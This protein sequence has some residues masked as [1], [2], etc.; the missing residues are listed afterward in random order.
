MTTLTSRLRGVAALVGIIAIVAGLPLL[1]VAAG[2]YPLADIQTLASS[3]GA[4]LLAP[5]DG[6]LALIVL[7]LVAWIA[8]VLMTLSLLLEAA[9]LVRGAR[10]PRLPGF[11]MPQ[12]VARALIG[13]A[14]LAFIAAPTANAAT[15][16]AAP[17]P[18]VHEPPVTVVSAPV[19][20]SQAAT[21]TTAEVKEQDA[22]P[23]L[24]HT[25]QAGDTLWDIAKTYLGDGM[26]FKEIV[27][28]NRNVLGDNPGFLD[29]GVE[30]SIPDEQRAGREAPA[31]EASAKDVVVQ[32][33]DTL[34][35]IAADELGDPGLYPE[36][37][38]A[39]RDITQPGGA[40]LTDP[41][42]IEPGWTVQVPGAEPAHAESTSTP[43]GAPKP[44]R[45]ELPAGP[46]ADDARDADQAPPDT[47]A[48]TTA[49]E[50]DS[51]A[52]DQ[53]PAADVA[54]PAPLSPQQDQAPEAPKQSAPVQE[55]APVQDTVE[56]PEDD[57]LGETT[58]WQATTVAGVG[59][60]LAAGV[61]ALVARRRRDQQRLR[62]PGQEMPLPTGPAAVFEQEIRAASDPLSIETVDTALRTLARHC[63]QTGQALPVVRAGRLTA[64]RFELYLEDTAQMPAPWIDT[65]E[66]K[67][68]TLEVEA[69][70]ELD[71]AGLQD[72]PAPYPS[73]VTIGH[74]D[75][76]GHVFLN[77]EHLGALGITGDDH[78][79]REILA[80][81][82]VELATSTWAD[83]LQVTL[84]G[85]FPEL[86][87]ALRTGRIRYLPTVGRIAEQLAQRAEADRQAM[88]DADVPDLYTARV[89]G[90]VPDTWYPEIVLLAGPI[91]ERQQ[92]QLA[93]LAEQLP[94]VALATITSGVS[95]G[96]WSLDLA[97]DNDVAVLSP[98]GLE[99]RPQRLPWE[100]YGHLLELVSI[101][102]VEELKGDAPSEPTVA[103]I[104]AV[105]PVDDT[106]GQA[107]A[108]PP[109]TLA[110]LE[111]P[112]ED[113]AISTVLADVSSEPTEV[114]LTAASAGMVPQGD[115]EPVEADGPDQDAARSADRALDSVAAQHGEEVPVVDEAPAAPR[116]L[117]LGKVDLVGAAGRVE[118][119]KRGR[120]LEYAA[121]LALHPGAN[122]TQIDAAIWPSRKNED[123]LSTRNTATSK[124]RSWVG[125][126]PQGEDYLPR[127]P[128]GGGY[129]FTEAVTTDVAL[130]D[131]LVNGDP[132]NATTETLE[133]ALKLVR[134]IPFDGTQAK[135]YAWAEPI[136]QRLT[137]EIV[138]ASYALGKRRLMQG[139]W[140]AAEE[141]VVVGIV[142]EPA[143]ECLW[144]IRI[145]AAHESRNPALEAR[146]VEQLLAFNEWLDCDLEPETNQ[147]LTALKD[148]GT[149]FDRLMANAL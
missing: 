50:A 69:S 84:V 128:S 34:S 129:A 86:E 41:N 62:R 125:K 35:Q 59:T 133:Q 94:H 5:D 138:D 24:R 56:Q 3:A 134:G 57:G 79:T 76:Q 112:T 54:A 118:P 88:A 82:A 22:A 144:R 10:A 107:S 139:R 116:I 66:A 64:D 114:P 109:V 102:D 137:A 8:W 140:R 119:T 19:D 122:H 149:D 106:P 36:I 37:Y 141:A 32:R 67:I 101:A 105:T 81:L 46:P 60:V 9:A 21:T 6:S 43:A 25:T 33:G 103:E 55:P 27:E 11:S 51:R 73:L 113:A 130:W 52:A 145:L 47:P 30:L 16:T 58:P 99:V 110:M 77:L 63:T 28:L 23:M 20:S 44:G 123:N 71:P 45:S 1:L 85:A 80:A 95:V 115:E 117:V 120:L 48:S 143:Q 42:H 89:T 70:H 126:D 40:R 127:N 53:Q 142:L 100:Q 131:E 49:P 96:E 12:G 15:A 146:L 26:R 2:A 104:E 29:V 65:A 13:T 111:T 83:D 14:M 97:A 90:T 17:A 148:P 61:L 91:T 7:R 31:G 39:S 74:D 87:D 72:V 121:F 78:G 132:L 98:I 93:D 68:W 38:E 124:L 92:A 108:M 75:E 4:L 136:K 18:V 135:R 147:L